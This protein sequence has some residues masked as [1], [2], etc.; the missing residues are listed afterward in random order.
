MVLRGIENGLERIVEGVFGR[1]FK[2]GLQPAEIGNQLIKEIDSCKRVDVDG[3][4]LAPNRFVVKLSPPDREQ[5]S[6]MKHT[7]TT[8]LVKKVRDYSKDQHLSFMGRVSVEI[9]QDGGLKQGFFNV[10]P[11]YDEQIKGP[12]PI[13]WLQMPSGDDVELTEDNFVVGRLEECNL[14]IDDPNVSR[15]HAELTRSGD[16]YQIADLGSTNGCKVNGKLVER[17]VLNDGD[18]IAF[19]AIVVRYR[20]G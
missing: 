20:Q 10:H 4:G 5:F 19:G 1:A 6:E 14:T 3:K 11:S 8:D 12:G 9:E 13:G 17:Q 7:L 16:T 2:S 18:E 15:R